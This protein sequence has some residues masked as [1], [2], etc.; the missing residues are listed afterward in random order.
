MKHIW[1]TNKKRTVLIFKARDENWIYLRK[2]IKII[3][4]AHYHPVSFR[5]A[6]SIFARVM[7]SEALCQSRL[8]PA[9]ERQVSF[10]LSMVEKAFD[11]NTNW[12]LHS[13]LCTANQCQGWA[14]SHIDEKFKAIGLKQPLKQH[15]ISAISP[16]SLP[17]LVILLNARTGSRHHWFLGVFLGC[18][19]D[20]NLEWSD[21]HVDPHTPGSDTENLVD[22]IIIW[23]M[24]IQTLSARKGHDA[25]FG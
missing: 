25:L 1:V 23:V 15:G 16:I 22:I 20:H 14:Q 12:I 8:R 10:S 19:N 18:S 21:I 11:F 9:F 4:V 13:K 2:D 7:E 6:N 3:P 5:A 17:G 24:R